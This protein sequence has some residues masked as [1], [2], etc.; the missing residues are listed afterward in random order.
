MMEV[1]TQVRSSNNLFLVTLLV[2]AEQF[3]RTTHKCG[4]LVNR[5]SLPMIKITLEADDLQVGSE[6]KIICHCFNMLRTS[7]VTLVQAHHSE[8]ASTK[9][10][11]A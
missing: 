5:E 1:D 8:L 6:M 11:S 10:P 2:M 9:R 7:C 4:R 3:S